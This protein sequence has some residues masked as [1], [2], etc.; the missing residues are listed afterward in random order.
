MKYWLRKII[1][2]LL[3][4]SLL[5]GSALAQGRIGTVDFKKLFENYWKKKEAEGTIKEREA[6]LLKDDKAMIDEFKKAKEDYTALL[7]DANN[8]ALS[9]DERDKRKKSAEEKFKQLKLMEDN[10]KEFES[11][12]KTRLGEQA[13]RMRSNLISEIRNVIA[14]KAKAAGLSMVLDTS[15]ESL[16]STLIVAYTTGEND[17]TDV[18]L[19][20]LNLGAHPTPAD[21]GEKKDDKKEEKKKAGG[22]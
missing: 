3:L 19:T 7:S 20:Q 10:I 6:E 5:S 17:I 14:A 18:V 8:Q 4:F 21:S 12:G 11:A 15:A 1:P 9:T 2:G 16:G 22:K 13:T